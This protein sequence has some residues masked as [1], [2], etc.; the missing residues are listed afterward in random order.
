[1][2][3]L[4]AQNIFLKNE[5][6]YTGGQSIPMLWYLDFVFILKILA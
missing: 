6:S 3:V 1:M 5:Q 2:G 4:V